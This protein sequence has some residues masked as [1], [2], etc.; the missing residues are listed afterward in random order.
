MFFLTGIPNT[1]YS[2]P[3]DIPGGSI[4]DDTV[5]IESSEQVIYDIYDEL[6]DKY[7]NYVTKQVMGEVSSKPPLSAMFCIASA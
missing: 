6:A 3:F 1:I 7:P 2:S 4:N 5:L